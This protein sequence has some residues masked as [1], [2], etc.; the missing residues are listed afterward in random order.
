MNGLHLRLRNIVLLGAA[1]LALS[2]CV[3]QSAKP[4]F[5]EE[6]GVAAL[7]TLGSRFESWTLE[8]DGWKKSE[9]AALPFTYV[10]HH[11]VVKGDSG[12]TFVQFVALEKDWY[13]IQ[14][15][16]P[17][18]ESVYAIAQ[19]NAADVL[20][21]PLMCDQLKKDAKVAVRVSFEGLDCTAPADWSLADF[22]A[23]KDRGSLIG[24]LKL[25]PAK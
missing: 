12:D 14:F 24:F 11:Y 10:S 3:L 21:Y 15:T 1:A 20:I 2:A 5:A 8:K 17:E 23:L 25:V 7:E 6:K 19:R 9:D 4:L 18:K 16:E 13:V 22:K